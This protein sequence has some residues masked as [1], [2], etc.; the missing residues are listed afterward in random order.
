MPGV[1]MAHNPSNIQQSQLE[2]QPPSFEKY[3]R[4]LHQELQYKN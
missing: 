1:A 2:L 3:G 4:Q